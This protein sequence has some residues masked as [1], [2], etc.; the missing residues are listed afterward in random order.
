MLQW[1]FRA[2]VSVAFLQASH[3]VWTR[4]EVLSPRPGVER[5]GA[6]ISGLES[7][8]GETEVL[9]LLP[10]VQTREEGG[11]AGSVWITLDISPGDST[12]TSIENAW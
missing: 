1:I 3:P 2:L 9:S 11:A 4:T 10:G 12:L 7:G 5:Q 6:R 8:W